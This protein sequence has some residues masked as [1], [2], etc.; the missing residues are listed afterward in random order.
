MQSERHADLVT[1]LEGLLDAWMAR[2]GH[3]IVGT[4]QLCGRLYCRDEGSVDNFLTLE[5]DLVLGKLLR[6]HLKLITTI[7]VAVLNVGSSAAW[8]SVRQK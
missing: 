8:N 3:Q 4:L 5:L 1:V 6:A 2:I 7:I